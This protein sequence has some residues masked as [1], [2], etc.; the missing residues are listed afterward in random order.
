MVATWRSQATSYWFRST[1]ASQ[2]LATLSL[3][4]ARLAQRRCPSSRMISTMSDD[5]PPVSALMAT[6]L[7]ALSG[8]CAS[9]EP[10]SSGHEL[11]IVFPR[12]V[13]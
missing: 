1:G 5:T 8:V 9:M 7:R 6:T 3:G 13:P 2:T 10:T 4:K 11:S 12:P